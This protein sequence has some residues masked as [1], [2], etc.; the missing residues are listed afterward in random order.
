ML[1]WRHGT[2][3]V[4]LAGAGGAAGAAAAAAC[5]LHL[6]LARLPRCFTIGTGRVQL[7]FLTCIHQSDFLDHLGQCG[8]GSAMGQRSAVT[9]LLASL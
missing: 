2:A 1:H 7:G 9:P 8:L 4:A 6:L 5:A 3:P